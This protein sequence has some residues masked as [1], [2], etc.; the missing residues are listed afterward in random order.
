LGFF[1]GRLRK[2]LQVDSSMM[3]QQ[4][5]PGSYPMNITTENGTNYYSAQPAFSRMA[6]G[7][8]VGFGKESNFVDFIFFR[9]YDDVKSITNENG[10]LNL[11]PEENVVLGIN[12]FQRFFKHITFGLNGAAS[13]YTYDTNV[14]IVDLEIPFIDMIN[15]IIPV[16]STT[17]IQWAAETN[18][19]ISYP[20]FSM[21]TSYKRAQPYFRSMGIN[22]FMTDLNLFS[23]QPSWS[24]LKQK[25]RFTNMFQFQSDNLNKYKQLTT[26]RLLLNSSV[27]YQ[28]SNNFGLDFNYNGNSISQ[29]KANTQ[30]ADSIQS[31]Q[32][33]NS[34][35]ISPRYIFSTDVL[36]DIVSLV[37]SVSNMKNNQLNGIS[38]DIKNTYATLNNTF[39]LFKGGWNINTGLNY[40]NAVTSQNALQSFG[41]IAGLSKSLFE[42]SFTLSNNNTVLFNTLDGVSNGTTVSVDLNGI[43]N[44][45]KRNTISV[46]FNY[47]FSPANGIYNL[48]DFQQTRLMLT[49]QYN[50]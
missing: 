35:T 11:K 42:N 30:T 28:V 21:L 34:L 32:K 13:I 31:S 1:G 22:S 50:F 12:I 24:I 38:N 45:L 33:S 37:A 8:K 18:F 15:K 20:N 23:V 43:Y 26:K 29:L 3:Y 40:N 17:Q 4:D 16:R 48:N 46:G 39:I 27:S 49:Y 2:A 25:I 10:S 7:A 14:D 44:F 41:F 6:W 9:G 5:I 47:L 36:S 19:N